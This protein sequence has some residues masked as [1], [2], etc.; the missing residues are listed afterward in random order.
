V[1][2]RVQHSLVLFYE[3]CRTKDGRVRVEMTM[4]MDCP[5]KDCEAIQGQY[6]SNAEICMTCGKKY[7]YG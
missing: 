2:S 3:T 5:N 6:E 7:A 1:V 4:D